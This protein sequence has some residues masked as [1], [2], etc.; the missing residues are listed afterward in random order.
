[1]T[2]KI[3]ELEAKIAALKQELET[4]TAKRNLEKEEFENRTPARHLAIMMHQCTCH[5]NHTDGC[6]WFHD[7]SWSDHAH[8]EELDR[9]ERLLS[10]FP[11][12]YANMDRVE[13]IANAFAGYDVGKRIRQI[14]NNK[15][16]GMAI[17][18]NYAL[19]AGNN[20]YPDGGADD[21]VAYFDSHTSAIAHAEALEKE[22]EDYKHD[23]TLPTPKHQTDWWHVTETT[24]MKIVARNG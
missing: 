19:F 3:V 6:S 13:R 9:A 8:K 4:E 23:Y 17:M 20:Y 14:E 12:Y 22:W 24:S 16:S 15:K 10:A 11:P 21:F 1:M 7:T 2:K 5:H 18:K